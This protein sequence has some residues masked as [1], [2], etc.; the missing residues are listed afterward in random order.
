[1]RIRI[2]IALAALLAIAVTAQ[3]A[4][5]FS[6]LRKQ[7]E[8]AATRA[9]GDVGVAVKHLESGTEILINADKK[10]PMASTYKLPILVEIYYQAAEGKFSLDDRVEVSPLKTA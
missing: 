10:F 4:D 3:A 2:R 6:Q 7:I 8:Q 5:D 1:M 9:R